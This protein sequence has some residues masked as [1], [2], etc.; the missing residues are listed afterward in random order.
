MTMAMT[1]T[2]PLFA[3][4]T[5]VEGKAKRSDLIEQRV[6]YADLNL[7]N[8][9]NQLIL[10]SRVKRAVGKVCDII[11][12]GQSLMMKFD[13]GCTHEVYRNAKPQIDMAIANAGSGTR[14]AISL[15]AKRSD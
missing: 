6:P 15:T 12:R 1:A 13:S 4:G 11:Y 9:S 5:V 3:Q 2:T 14:V 8:R 7:E 10:I